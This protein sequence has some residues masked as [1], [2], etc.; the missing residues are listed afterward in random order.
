MF[1]IDENF[2]RDFSYVRAVKSRFQSYLSFSSA[3]SGGISKHLAIS[4]G[5]CVALSTVD[6][7]AHRMPQEILRPDPNSD[8]LRLHGG[9][10]ISKVLEK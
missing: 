3:F 10:G 6:F 4:G 9:V 5:A 1:K 7:S 8:A 2:V